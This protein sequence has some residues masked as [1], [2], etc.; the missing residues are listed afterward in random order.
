MASSKTQNDSLFGR[1]ASQAEIR[2]AKLEQKMQKDK[3]TLSAARRKVSPTPVS[4]YKFATW[5]GA[6]VT[7]SQLFGKRDELIVIHNMGKRCPYCTMWADGFNGLWRHLHDRARFV[8]ISPDPVSVQKRFGAGRGWTFPM[9]SAHKT[10]FFRDMGF[11]SEKGD[12]WP[13]VSVF[14]RNAQGKMFRTGHSYF[15]P[16][17]NFCVSWDFIDM[18]PK[19]QNGWEP[20][21]SYK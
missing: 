11:A 18:L 8:V 12:P 9:H 3:K 7:L 1:Y 6:S 17:D 16:G 5:E 19:G 15:G 14:T 21:Y 20:Q 4:D 13:G 10:S 2:V